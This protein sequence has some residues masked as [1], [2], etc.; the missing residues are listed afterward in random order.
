MLQQQQL[1]HVHAQ[2]EHLKKL[3]DV[4]KSE[5]DHQ[6]ALYIN[7]QVTTDLKRLEAEYEQLRVRTVW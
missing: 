4:V 2:L 7:K 3:N 1:Q 6:E 5:S